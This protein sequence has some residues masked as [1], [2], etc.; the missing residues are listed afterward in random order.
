MHLRLISQFAA[1]ARPL[2]HWLVHQKLVLPHHHY[3]LLALHPVQRG[4]AEQTEL[5]DEPRR[6]I[7]STGGSSGF[8]SLERIDMAA[9][10][11]AL[12]WPPGVGLISCD[13]V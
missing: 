1:S 11:M 2:A 3:Y 9:P 6:P 10:Q 4:A 8:L 5:T 13:C 7:T 12:H